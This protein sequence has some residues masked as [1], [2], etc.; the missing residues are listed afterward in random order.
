[1][2][3]TGSPR[4][5][6]RT[7]E[8]IAQPLAMSDAARQLLKPTFAARDYLETLKAAGLVEDAIRFLAAALPKREAVWWA[9]LCLR[10]RLAKPLAL[11]TEKAVVAAETWV[12]EGSEAARRNAEKA[13]EQVGWGT[14]AGCAAAGAFWSGGSM[15]PANVPVVP[16]REDLTGQAVAASLAFVCAADPAN[17]PMIRQEIFEQGLAISAGKFRWDAKAT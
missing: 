3:P 4:P 13:A 6:A 7:A 11:L 8:A 15:A 12:R 10:E 17:A 16:P 9:C 2:T 1:M 14:A 5:A